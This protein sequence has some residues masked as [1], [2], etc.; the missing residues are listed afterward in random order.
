MTNRII[1]DYAVLKQSL[2]VDAIVVKTGAK[3]STGKHYFT[4]TFQQEKKL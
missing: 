4:T 1:H 3:F 2:K